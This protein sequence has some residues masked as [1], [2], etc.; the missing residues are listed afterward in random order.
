PF[1]LVAEKTKVR[2]RREKVVVQPETEGSDDED[3]SD[4]KKIIALLAKDFNRKK[5]YAKLTNNNLRTSSASSSANKKPEYVK[6]EEKKKDKKADEQKRDM[7]KVNSSSAEETIAE[8]SY[9]TSDSERKS[10]YETSEYYDN[11]T[12]YSLFVD[13]D[14]DEEIFHDVNESASEN[15]NENHIVSQ[16][17]HDESEVD[18]N[19]SEEKD[20]LVDKLIKKFNQ[21]IAKCFENPSYFCKAKELRPS[22]Y[23]ERVIGL[24]YTPMFLTH[25]DEALKIEKFKRAR[26]N[27]IEFAYDYENL[28]ASYVN[29]KINFSNDY[30]QEIINLD[31]EK[32]DSAFQQTSSLKPYVL[33]V[34]LEKIIIDLEDEVASLLKKEKEN[35][36]IIESLKSKVFESSENAISESKNQSENDCQVIKKAC[37]NLENSKVIAPGMFKINMSQN[38]S[39]IS[40]SK[41]FC[42][43]NYVENK[44]KRK[45]HKRMSLK[46]ID[47]QVNN[48]VVRANR[49]FVY[50][51]DLDTLS[52]VRRPRHS[53]VIWKK[54][55]SPNTSS[56][57]LS[58]VSISKLNKDV[59]RYSRKNLL[60]CNNSH[61]VDTRSAYACNDAMNVSWRIHQK[62][63]KSKA[64]FASNKPLYLLYMDMCSPMRIESINGKRYVL[65]VVDDYSR[66]YLLNNFDDVGKLN[67]KGDIGVLVGYSK[68]F[69]AFKIYNKRTQKIHESVNVNFDE[70]SEMASKQFSLEPSLS[71]LI[72]TGKYSNPTVSQ[73]SKTSKKDLEDLFHNFYD[74]Y[75]DAS[76]ITKSPTTN[77][78]TFN[79]EIPSYTEEVFH[80]S[81]KSFQEEYFSSS[82][83]D[84]VQQSSE[85][86]MVPPTN[87]QSVSNESVP[88]VNEAS[89]DY[90]E[91]FAPVARIEAIRLFLAYA[92]HKDFTIFQMDVKTAFF[93]GILKEEV[94]V[95]QP[96]G[97]VSKQYLDHVYA[98]DKALYGL[99]QA[100]RAQEEEIIRLKERVQVLEDR[101]D[102]PIKGRSNNEGEVAH[103]LDISNE[104]T[105]FSRECIEKLPDNSEYFLSLVTPSTSTDGQIRGPCSTD[106]RIILPCGRLS[107][108]SYI[109]LF[110]ESNMSFSNIGGRLSAPDKITL[111]ARL[112]IEQCDVKNYETYLYLDNGIYD[113][114]ER[115][116]RPLALRQTRRPQSDRGKA[117]HF[118]SSSS[119]HHQGTSSHQH[120][121]DDDVETSRAS[122]PSPTT[123]LNSLCPLDHQNYH[124][125]SS[126]KQTDETLFAR[127]T[128][129]LNQTQRMHEEMREGFKSFE[130]ELKRVFSKKKNSPNAPSK[131]PSTKDTSSLSIDYTPKSPTL[132]SSSFTNGY[133]NSSLSPP[134]RVPPPPPTQA[135]NSMEI[136]LSLSPITPLDVHHNSPSLSPPIIGHPIP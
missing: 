120:D 54:K 132:L 123:Y 76:K 3:I 20:H 66:C 10:K 42:A 6:S 61:H 133:L 98:L 108:Y 72:E 25:L 109:L 93:T 130:K 100:P 67:A 129:L 28:N 79:D 134:P 2:K 35:L 128:T 113:I 18:H 116:M 136:T 53:G 40:V 1:A 114:V 63:H 65:V 135:P 107:M 59:K 77:V 117:H 48:D 14:D 74:E 52:S 47:K 49:D 126:S 32:I 95:G 17:D 118:V 38:I 39:P 62:H 82:L 11:S 60:S 31:F 78:E 12:N 105:P 106:S 45:R 21:K 88:N 97:F 131:T 86:V 80:E 34:I 9:Y 69:V 125:P 85:E 121:D 26:E 92:T 119:S 124:V 101:E 91:M 56:V 58:F 8:V 115:V 37:D 19:D 64:A 70:I 7:I 41:M 13:N 43:S 68:E 87:T 122:T 112:A 83:N 24:G 111:S 29:E 46:Q 81:S 15:F 4:L 110:H 55:W 127:Q 104:L 36:E 16:K 90:D 27:K 96:P 102:S 50:F 89:I 23:D 33:T 73:V 84:D 51:L 94:Y 57:D 103:E 44:T 30:F 99:K 5:Y 71:N 22:L 75:F